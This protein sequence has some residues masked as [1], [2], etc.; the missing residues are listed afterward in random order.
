MSC[1]RYCPPRSLFITP[2]VQHLSHA[3]SLALV[4]LRHPQKQWPWL[5]SGRLVLATRAT[6][7]GS[8]YHVEN[9]KVP[10]SVLWI[11][12]L[13]PSLGPSGKV[14]TNIKFDTND[15]VKFTSTPS[16]CKNTA[17]KDS[18]VNGSSCQIM[19]TRMSWGD[20]SFEVLAA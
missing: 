8:E 5:L 2:T 16:S 18:A 1:G 7:S 19:R 15:V 13:I 9:F 10:G 6:G 14:A 11:F 3:L 12:L 17:C 20:D 4:W